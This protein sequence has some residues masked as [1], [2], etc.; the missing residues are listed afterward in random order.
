MRA[1]TA[2]AILGVKRPLTAE[3][4]KKAFKRK[5][6]ETHPDLGGDPE[7]FK[8]VEEARATLEPW[9]RGAGVETQDSKRHKKAS[10]RSGQENLA[11]GTWFHVVGIRCHGEV[12]GNARAQLVEMCEEIVG[13]HGGMI[14]KRWMIAVYLETPRKL[15]SDQVEAVLVVEEEEDPTVFIR[16]IQQRSYDIKGRVTAFWFDPL[17]APML[18]DEMH[19]PH[20]GPRAFEGYYWWDVWEA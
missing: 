2:E 18:W 3:V 9:T 7:A 14:R 17:E 4:L 20:G 8:R 5:A 19:K 6:R 13:I 12:L 11:V 16:T 1:E 15:Q 10:R